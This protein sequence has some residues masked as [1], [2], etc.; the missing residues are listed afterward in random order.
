MCAIIHWCVTWLLHMW[1]FSFSQTCK[2]AKQSC[3]NTKESCQNVRLSQSYVLS[4][5]DVWHDSFICDVS[6]LCLIWPIHRCMRRSLV[7]MRKSLAKMYAWLI[8]VVIW[9]IDVW[10]D[11]FIHAVAHSC[12]MCEWVI[13]N[14]SCIQFCKTLSHLSKESCN[15]HEKLLG[16]QRVSNPSIEIQRISTPAHLN[17][18][19]WEMHGSS[20]L[21]V[22]IKQQ[23]V[24]GV[25]K[26]RP[27][28]FLGAM[29]LLT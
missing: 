18:Y 22:Q 21:M 24:Y 28:S 25:E 9:L 15:P 12:V 2:N 17:E 26:Q 7:K 19:K 16:I 11:S 4:S 6:P 23:G 20:E 27:R 14:V 10:H 5:I 13:V 8:H 1:R 29:V 3:K